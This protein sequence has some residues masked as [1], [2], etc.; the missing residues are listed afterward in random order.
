MYLEVKKMKRFVIIIIVFLTL[1]A[2]LIWIPD[3]KTNYDMTLYLPEDSMTSE[4]I[5]VLN[6]NFDVSS[7]IQ[8]MIEDISVD[9]VI[10]Y[11]SLIQSM[12]LVDSVIWLDD[13]VDIQTIPLE[14]IPVDTLSQFYNDQNALLTIVFTTDSYDIEL[15][16]AIEDIRLLFDEEIIRFR[17][18]PIENIRAKE[19]AE[20]EIFKILVLI[21]PII[22]IILLLAS[23]A[24]IEPVLILIALGH[25]CFIQCIH[26]WYLRACFI[27]Y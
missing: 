13:Y 11:K 10:M 7:S 12:E 14:W 26:Q 25:C 20:G 15:E 23:H 8:L 22:L 6:D 9:D 5:Q 1:I 18:E 17:G 16:P 3:S 21:I 27:H 4:G 24:W 2:S 19:V